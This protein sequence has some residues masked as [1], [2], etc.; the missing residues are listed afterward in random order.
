M[1]IKI[2]ATIF[3]L[4]VIVNNNRAFAQESMLRDI[5]EGYVEKLIQ[6]AKT[7]YPRY[8]SFRNRTASAKVDVSLASVSLLDALTLS[9]VYQPGNTTI[10]DPENPT[11]GNRFKGFQAGLFI[12]L[13]TIVRMPLNVKKAKAQLRMAENDQAE[14]DLTLAT[15]VKKR[16]YTYIQRMGQLKVITRAMQQAE[17]S[18]KDVEYRYKKGEETYDTYNK[19][20]IQVTEQ[21]QTKIEAEAQVFITKAGLEE[22]IGDKL[23]NIR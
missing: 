14:Y 20:Q 3:I 9:Y 11:S 19:T 21:T 1:K 6:V 8:K 10:I 4:F 7:N 13:G 5:S 23:E 18:L 12:N 15:E 22:M 17:N 2:L 16:Y